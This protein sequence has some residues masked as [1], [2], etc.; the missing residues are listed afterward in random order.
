[1]RIRITKKPDPLDFTDIDVTHFAV[2]G[3]YDIPSAVAYVL[4]VF[5][6]AITEMRAVEPPD[7]MPNEKSLFRRKE[8]KRAN[9]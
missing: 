3:A 6:Y 1:M 9:R 7:Q 8:D 5:G 2:G 4:I